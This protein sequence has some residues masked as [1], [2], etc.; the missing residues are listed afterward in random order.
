MGKVKEYA[1]ERGMNPSFKKSVRWFNSLCRR[2]SIKIGN[3]EKRQSRERSAR[4]RYR[5]IFETEK[6]H[7]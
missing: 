4:S 5:D 7:K 2:E 3:E 1:T 6:R